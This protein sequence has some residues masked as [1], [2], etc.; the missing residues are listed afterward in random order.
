MLYLDV[1]EFGGGSGIVNIKSYYN[2]G[3][4]FDDLK[5]IFV[6]LLWLLFKDE[7]CV[8]GWELGLLEE[9]VVC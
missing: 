4:L 1:V 5:F 2:V 8:V 9:I 6:E 3:G 7:V